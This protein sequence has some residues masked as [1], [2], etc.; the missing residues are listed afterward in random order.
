MQR[1]RSILVVVDDLATPST[2]L[3][4]AAELA[5]RSGARVTIVSAVREQAHLLDPHSGGLIEAASRRARSERTAALQELVERTR[6]AGAEAEG[7]LLEGQPFV[8]I[9]REVL[10]HGHDLVVKDARPPRGFLDQ[11]F[12]SLDL[13]LLRKVPVPVWM[14]K[15]GREGRYRSIVAAVDPPRRDGDYAQLDESIVDLAAA[16]ARL[17]G[18]TLHLV[19]AYELPDETMLRSARSGLTDAQVDELFAAER[20]R[21]R[22]AVDALVR[23]RAVGDVP[24]EIHLLEGWAGSE[25]PPAVR[26]LEAD[27]LVLGTVARTGLPG[28]IVGNTAE[29]ILHD[30]RCAVLAL[31]PRGFVSPVHLPAGEEPWRDAGV[32]G[33]PSPVARPESPA[34][35]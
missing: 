30:V 28:F 10:R 2:A 35:Q 1:F 17:H 32:P 8:E 5:A 20:Q 13:H 18:A 26:L 4:H 34:R 27:L 9:V 19:H 22:E 7:R 31:K 15:P 12:T 24:V 3:A 14:V 11:V 29:T 33:G 23:T 21:R 16:M 6:S 25:I